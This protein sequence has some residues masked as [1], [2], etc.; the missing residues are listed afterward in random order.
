[1]DWSK[2]ILC[3]NFWRNSDSSEAVS[4]DGFEN[5]SKGGISAWFSDLF[6]EEI[7]VESFNG[8]KE[9]KIINNSITDFLKKKILLKIGS[10]SLGRFGKRTRERIPEEIPIDYL[11][12]SLEK[13]PKNSLICKRISNIILDG[14]SKRSHDNLFLKTLEKIFRDYLQKALNNFPK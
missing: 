11:N 4:G 14:V 10:F 5:T 1:M 7:L 6:P 8:I 3:W 13:F 2:E 9:K 12:I